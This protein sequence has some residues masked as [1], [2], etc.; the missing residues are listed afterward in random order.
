MEQDDRCVHVSHVVSRKRGREPY[1]LLLTAKKLR[2]RTG[3]FA[4]RSPEPASRGFDQVH[5][6]PAETAI[7]AFLL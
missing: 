1:A 7:L 3:K 6:V 2:R 5:V 4:N